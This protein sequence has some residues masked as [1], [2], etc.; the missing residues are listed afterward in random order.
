[1]DIINILGVSFI[2][3]LFTNVIAYLIQRKHK[4]RD[5][6]KSEKDK[7]IVSKSFDNE[8]KLFELINFVSNQYTFD[9][10]NLK[11][12]SDQINEI[13]RENFLYINENIYIL[14]KEFADYLLL[15]SVDSSKMDK[16]FEQKCIHKFK[17][18]FVK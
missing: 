14:C 15:V 7:L 11:T 5:A 12:I 18:E 6:F 3:S 17:D 10:N 9:S 8:V 13:R 1:M 4:I 2:T 16:G